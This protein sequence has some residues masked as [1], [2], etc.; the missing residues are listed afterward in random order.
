[1]FGGITGHGG[2]LAGLLAP[3][4]GTRLT[5]MPMSGR[6]MD[7]PALPNVPHLCRPAL[8]VMPLVTP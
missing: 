6:L 4:S 2:E 5:R 1:M 7:L 8:E 3:L